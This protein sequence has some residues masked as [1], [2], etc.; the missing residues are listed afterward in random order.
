MDDKAQGF[1]T[2]EYGREHVHPD[3][4]YSVIEEII[5]DQVS[6]SP[7]SNVRVS[8]TGNLMRIAYHCYEMHLPVKMKEIEATAKSVLDETFKNL[9]KQFKERTSDTLKA[10]EQ[11]DMANYSVQK[12]SLNER[13]Y[14]VAW[15]F[16]ELG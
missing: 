5:R 7:A 8:F 11:K 14:Y 1:E 6:R 12:V 15:R 16:Y 9:K 3:K 10:K 4:V 2:S 13:Y